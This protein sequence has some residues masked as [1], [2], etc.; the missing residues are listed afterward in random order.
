MV[1]GLLRR[2]ATLVGAISLLAVSSVAEA[3]IVGQVDT[4]EDGTT[5]NWV[6]GGALGLPVTPPTNS[7]SGGPLGADDAFLLLNS[8]G[9]DGPGSRLTVLNGSQWS[10]DYLAAGVTGIRMDV[11]NLGQTDVF[12]RLLFEDLPAVPGPHANLAVTENAVHVPA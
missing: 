3:V 8:T 2:A 4:F 11:N 7:P 6:V 5:M 1:R 10:G 12:L 9:G